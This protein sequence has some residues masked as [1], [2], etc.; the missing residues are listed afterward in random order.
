MIYS[1]GN[2]APGDSCTGTD[3]E[4]G[5]FVEEGWFCVAARAEDRAGNV[6][7]SRPLRLCFDNG[8]GDPPDCS[9]PPEC[10]DGCRAPERVPPLLLEL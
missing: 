10:T 1:V 8:D 2:N 6:G 5:Q 7:I 3:W 4:I 9:S